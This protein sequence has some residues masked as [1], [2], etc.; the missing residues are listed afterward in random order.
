MQRQDRIVRT[1]ERIEKLPI[2]GG[3]VASIKIV[4]NRGCTEFSQ[5]KQ[6]FDCK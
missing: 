4:D 2:V 6:S 1:L 5:E 3:E